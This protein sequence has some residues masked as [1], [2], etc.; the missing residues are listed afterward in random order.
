MEKDDLNLIFK[1]IERGRCLAFLGAGA[2]TS[3][4]DSQGKDIPGLPTGRELAEKV[5]AKCKYSNGHPDD[6]LKVAEYFVYTCSGDRQ[7]LEKAVRAEI[8]KPCQPRPIHTVLAQLE[9]VKI[10]ITSNYD[11]LMEDEMHKY[12][13][14]LVTN[15]YS[16]RSSK[17]AHFNHSPLLEDGEVVLHKMHGT[18]EDPK[19]IVITESDYIYYL[20]NL[21]DK[22]RGMPEYFRKTWIP[23]CTWL[24]LGYSLGDWNFR[25]IWEGVLAGYTGANVARNAYALVREPTHQQKKYWARR[26]IDLVEQDLSEFAKQLARYFNL[27]IPLLGI[28]KQNPQST[29]GTP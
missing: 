26:N 15:A 14:K 13:R 2:C 28:T 18:V 9:K 4:K 17:A 11:T 16:R 12:G 8:Q 24:F 5:A 7:D 3:F 6:L 20:A 19:S 29:G 23:H 22:D 21:Y 10:I 27:E 1:A 25:V